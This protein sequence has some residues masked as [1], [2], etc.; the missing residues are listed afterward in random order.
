MSLLPRTRQAL[1]NY[2]SLWQRNRRNLLFDV[3]VDD[4]SFKRWQ[5]QEQEDL[6]RVREAFAADTADRN[7]HDRAM[8]IDLET[9]RRWVDADK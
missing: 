8:L 6:Q 1:E 3:A 9:L 7:S 4:E 5:K 2:D